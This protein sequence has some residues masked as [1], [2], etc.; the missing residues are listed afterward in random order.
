MA[1]LPTSLIPDANIL[2]SFFKSDS[3]RRHVIKELLKKGTKFFSPED[4]LKELLSNKYKIIKFSGI[5]ELEFLYL[6]SLLDIFI[7]KFS[8]EEYSKFLPEANKISPHGSETK[9][10]PYFALALSLN[11]AV[12][13]DEIAF[14]KQGKVKIF[15]T[16]E[17]SK[18]LER[19]IVESDGSNSE[20]K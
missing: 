12:W 13:S 15:N 2:F 10:D 9:D 8:M 17:L 16:S 5:S 18:L 14:K 7:E 6:F 3:A 20:G 11:C 19:S 1:L 4:A